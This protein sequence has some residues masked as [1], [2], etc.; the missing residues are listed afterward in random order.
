MKNNDNT[1]LQILFGGREVKIEDVAKLM[2]FVHKYNISELRIKN[3][4]DKIIIRSSCD[5]EKDKSY[6]TDEHQGKNQYALYEEKTY[7]V[8]EK[9]I[10]A[11]LV[12]VFYS[13]PSAGS[14]NFVKI[15]DRI[16]EGQTIAIIEAMKL[17]NEIKSDQTGIID[18]I[19]VENGQ[20]VEYGQ[21][22]FVIK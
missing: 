16:A 15:G 5:G 11:P 18:K 9:I 8:E 7:K 12:G 22:L 21:P 14:E 10:K 1:G 17:M 6:T 4:E 20:M 19:L 3:N 13:A 2:E